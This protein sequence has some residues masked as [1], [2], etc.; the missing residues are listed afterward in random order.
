MVY[1]YEINGLQLQTGDLICTKD[2]GGK[3]MTGQ[4]WRLIGKLIPGDVDHIVIYTGPN[5]KCV[6]VAAKGCVV[7]FDVPSNVWDA[8]GMISQRGPILDNLYGV[9]YPLDARRLSPAEIT[10]IRESVAAY[11][12][13]QAMLKKPYNLNFM[14][15]ST[16]DAFYCSQLAYKAYLGNGVDLNIGTGIPAIIGTESIIFPQEIWNG[17]SHKSCE[18]SGHD[19][20][21]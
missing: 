3:D 7:E 17:C 19:G 15:S 6:E 4:F 5:G 12:I 16:E 20:K 1:A 9:A 13:R 21:E 2:G 18:A 8:E 10:Q 11:C 14:V